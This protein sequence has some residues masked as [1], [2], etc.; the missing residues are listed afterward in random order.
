MSEK[1]GEKLALECHLGMDG[2]TSKQMKKPKVNIENQSLI[3]LCN[4]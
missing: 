4:V 1:I 3:S 2:G